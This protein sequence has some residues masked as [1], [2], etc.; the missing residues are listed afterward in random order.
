MLAK[1][2]DPYTRFLEPSKYAT[3]VNAATGEVAGVG[4]ELL[5]RDGECVVSDTQVSSRE[6]DHPVRYF[7][8]RL[9]RSIDFQMTAGHNGNFH[10]RL[11]DA[12]H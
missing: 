1:L 8:Q 10:Y 2:D 4:V 12:L 9:R 7:P 3:M 5:D 6:Y 11:F